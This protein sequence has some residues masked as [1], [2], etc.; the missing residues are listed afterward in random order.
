MRIEED[1]GH[2]VR[3]KRAITSLSLTYLLFV[4]STFIKESKHNNKFLSLI[5]HEILFL[6]TN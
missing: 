4:N 1:I 3:V 2:I 6:I 5:N